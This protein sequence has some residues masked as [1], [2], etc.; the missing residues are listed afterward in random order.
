MAG[1]N[2]GKL[3]ESSMIHQTKPSKLVLLINNLLADLLIR[4]TFFHQ[5]L[6]TTRF[7]KLPPT[8]LSLYMVCYCA[9]NQYKHSSHFHISFQGTHRILVYKSST[10]SLLII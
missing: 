2:V 3:G 6:K 9:S 1:G 4:Q 10:L 8:K 7:T 5:M